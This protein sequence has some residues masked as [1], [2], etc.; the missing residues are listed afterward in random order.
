MKFTVVSPDIYTYGAMLIGGILRDEG[1]NVSLSTKLSVKPK[2]TLMLSLFSTQHLLS[3]EIKKLV[4]DHRS[5][6]GKVYVGGPVSA[7][8][9]MVLGELEPDC[10]CVG[11]GEETVRR[12][13]RDGFSDDCPGLA[14]Y[15]DG[16]E[17]VFT[18]KAERVDVNK[19]P[20]PLIPHDI[21]S[22]DIRGASAYIETHRGCTGGCTFCQVPRYFGRD[23]Q[24]R[25]IDDILKEVREF[26]KRG[27]KRLSV[28]GGTGSL[29]QYKNG[30]INEEKFIE[31]M[32]GMAEIMGP[33]NISS[34]D[35]R[36]DCIS[37]DILE[38]IRNYT[39][40]WIFFGLESGSDR[41][42][43]KMGKGATADQAAEAVAACHEHGLKAAGSFIVGYPGETEEDYEMTKDFITMNQLDDVFISIAEPIPKTPLADLVLRTPDEDN[44]VFVPHT[45]E[46]KA[47][48]ITEAEARSFDLMMHADLF[49]TNMRPVTNDIFD[50]Y[51]K[52]VRKDGD[53]IRR[54]TAVLRKYYGG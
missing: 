43:K 4:K 45:G 25:S 44:P 1:Y 54:A 10:V 23:I 36:V 11:E 34:P 14:F 31:L 53:D 27:A 33:K 7:Y 37:D 35:I 39:I 19:R 40:G 24:S 5:K 6:G 8:F 2:E 48:K 51:L 29:F 21:G 28:S 42:L 50:I 20:I 9:E 13:A 12:L 32:K 49:R 15:D 38:A 22:Q 3:D 47:L 26:K 46:Y 16:S 17:I 52:N 30:E 18:G 41:V